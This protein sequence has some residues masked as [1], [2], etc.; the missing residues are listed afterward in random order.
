MFEESTRNEIIKAER[1]KDGDRVSFIGD[2]I[3]QNGHYQ[4]YINAYYITRFPKEKITFI[5]SGIAG[6]NSGDV[7]ERMEYDVFAENFSHAIV[8]L[9]MNDIGRENYGMTNPNERILEERHK[10]LEMYSCNV[11]KILKML[12]KRNCK[13]DLLT[14]SPYDQTAELHTS[15][16]FKGVNDALDICAKTARKLSGKYKCGLIE[17]HAAMTELNKKVQEEN[18]SATIISEDR[19][20]P[21]ELGS[22]MMAYL[23]LK[24]QDVSRYVAQISLDAKEQKITRQENCRLK[25][26]N[27][28]E[29]EIIFSYQPDSLPYPVNE[30]Y[31]EADRLVGFTSDLNSEILRVDGLSKDM[32]SISMNDEVLCALPGSEFE[33]GINIALQKESLGQKKSLALLELLDKKR[34]KEDLLRINCMMRKNVRQMNFNENDPTQ[35]AEFCEKYLAEMKNTP[36]YDYSKECMDKFFENRQREDQ[37][38]ADIRNIIEEI[39]S[40]NLPEP[41]IIKIAHYEHVAAH[42][43][44]IA[45]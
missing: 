9:G 23:F 37:I 2:S 42:C 6:N 20:H 39:Y 32:Y 26:M 44:H 33:K 10:L 7:L 3:T 24:S 28:N 19:V 17:L 36:W 14:P 1:Y 43:E 25:I 15:E 18:P 34:A 30:A 5:N 16:N 27:A 40:R 38:R 8:M 11:E 4:K 12:L 21:G 13:V 29:E 22:I 45:N 31:L 41:I 35:L